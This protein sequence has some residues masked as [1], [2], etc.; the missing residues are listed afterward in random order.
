VNV[1]VEEV[2]RFREQDQPGEADFL[3]DLA[4][5]G[6]QEMRIV[7]L[8]VSPGLEPASELSVIHGE[9]ALAV[10]VEHE[11]AGGEVPGLKVVAAERIAGRGKEV[12]HSLAVEPLRAVAGKVRDQELTEGAPSVPQGGSGRLSRLA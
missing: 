4:E 1:Q 11:A 3:L 9:Q 8:H 10:L 7:R 6:G 5:R 12:E 2:R